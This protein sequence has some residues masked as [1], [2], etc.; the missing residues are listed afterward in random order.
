MKI[1]RFDV[2]TIAIPL[3]QSVHHHLAT[4]QTAENILVRAV[5]DTGLTGW[6]ESCPRSYVSGE[7]IA[8]VAV[9]LRDVL[10]PPFVGRQVKQPEDL[11]EQL[12]C[13]LDGLE[14]N[15]HAAFCACELSLLDLA[16]KA[17][18]QSA[19]ER[20]GPVVRDPV[21]YSGVLAS[22][23]P[24]T[25]RAQAVFMRDA[26]IRYV[27]VKLG[28]SLENN[29][30]LL[31]EV[32]AVF[33]PECSI[34]A[35]ANCA[36]SATEALRQLEA[37]RPFLLSGIEQPVPS[38]DM[39]GMQQITAAGITPVVADESLCSYPDAIRLIEHKACHIFN[40]RVSKCG[41]LLNTAR[42]YRTARKSGIGCQLGAQV[43]ETGFLSAAGR[44]IGARCADLVWCEGSY[45]RYLLEQD[46]VQPDITI[47]PG[48]LAP[49]ITSPGIGVEA[50][51]NTIGKY[52]V[53]SFTVA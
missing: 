24:E 22:D 26:G 34:R 46:I 30:T 36:W 21:R 33:G 14:R 35:D 7:T 9:N 53:A 43:G 41:G 29:R 28:A 27:K 18:G 47:G 25:V 5:A 15:Q 1:V 23:N 8:S 3:L 20:V 38:D 13:L 48:G 42:I 10:L 51:D 19:G 17:A 2:I 4:R 32:R 44:H 49:A 50:C 39:L 37:L 52:T 40:L 11:Q 31:G 6:G 45:G 12:L 16:G